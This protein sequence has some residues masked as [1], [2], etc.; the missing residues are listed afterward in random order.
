MGDLFHEDVQD[1]FIDRVFAV[2]ILCPEHIFQVLTKRPERMQRYLTD[3]EPSWTLRIIDAMRNYVGRGTRLAGSNR[4]NHLRD[5]ERFL[6]IPNVWL[7]TSAEDQ[8]AADERIPHLLETPA[9]VRF[10][11]FEPLLGPVD[12]TRVQMLA[13]KPPHGPG[14]WLNALNGHVIGPD[15]QTDMKLDWVIV[16]GESGP[17]ARPMHPQWV[18]DIRDQCV[19]AGVSFFF[20][21]WGEWWPAGGRIIENARMV[22]MGNEAFYRLGKKDAGRELDGLVWDEFPAEKDKE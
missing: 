3:D 13:P 2:M 14:A 20:K 21:Q 17:R 19:S 15:D 1:E 7:G 22:I 12:P 5:Q 16:G 10:V 18:R 6:P 8:D 11:S 4:T 9:A